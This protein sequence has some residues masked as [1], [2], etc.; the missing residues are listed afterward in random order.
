MHYLIGISFFSLIFFQLFRS[1]SET[2]SHVGTAVDPP[3]RPQID[4]PFLQ[5]QNSWTSTLQ[6]MAVEAK[7]GTL[8]SVVATN[9]F[10]A[11]NLQFMAAEKGPQPR[12]KRR[13]SESGVSTKLNRALALFKF[14]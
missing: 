10:V 9:E 13:K 4:D 14:L 12:Q 2:G 7:N 5:L 11:F 6:G 3:P 8:T 1:N